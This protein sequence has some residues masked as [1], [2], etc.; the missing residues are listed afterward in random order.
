MSGKPKVRPCKVQHF[1]PSELRVTRPSR[2]SKAVDDS[3]SRSQR[4]FLRIDIVEERIANEHSQKNGD[5]KP[6]VVSAMSI[7]TL[8]RTISA[9][10]ENQHEKHAEEHLHNV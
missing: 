10:H 5:A 3:A 9:R 7:S 6:C 1:A 8:P 2:R 4:S